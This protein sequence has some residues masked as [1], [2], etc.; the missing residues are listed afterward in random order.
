MTNLEKY[1]E[2]FIQCFRVDVSALT[3]SF[4]IETIEKWDSLA[5]MKLIAAIE[6]A[7]DILFDTDDIIEFSSY[8]NGITILSKYDI[9]I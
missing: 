1:N 3:P 6:E 9:I 8:E 2:A 5:Q 4:S 7:F